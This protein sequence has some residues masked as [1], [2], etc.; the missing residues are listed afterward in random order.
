MLLSQ[1]CLSW[2]VYTINVYQGGL[3]MKRVVLLIPHIPNPRMLKRV[4]TLENDF[5]ISLIYWD[6]LLENSES[7]EISSQHRLF[8]IAIKAPQGKP[9]SR[10]FPLVMFLVKSLSVLKAEKPNIIH[11]AE[12]DMLFIAN[13][14]RLLYDSSVRIIYE[15]GDLYKFTFNVN[16]KGIKKIG[17]RI[18]NKIEEK[19]CKNISKIILTSPYFWNVYY[20][21]FVEQE[22]YLFIPNTP[23]KELFLNYKKEENRIFTIGFI[24]LIR[25]VEQLKLLINAVE[26]L[27]DDIRILIAGNGPGYKQII[28]YSRNKDFVQ[29]YGPYNYE[30]EIIQL[31]SKIDFVYSVYDTKLNNV[32]VAMPNKLYEAIAC[33]L[34]IIVADNTA[35][36]EFV[37]ENNIGL[38]TKNDDLQQL[39]ECILKLKNDTNL[40]NQIKRN[41]VNIKEK[42][43]DESNRVK[44]LK[45]YKNLLK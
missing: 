37:K 18:F 2:F 9:L 31:Y 5:N 29:I 30:K 8:K 33:E 4:K 35:L 11:V 39:K 14:Y 41:C 20:S 6:R 23:S 15:I 7:F 45:H 13:I 44:L 27:N 16:L 3:N 38:A 24:G 25:Y 28:E 21:K 26:D 34:P 10:V 19:L 40:T 17:G 36:G 43:Y 22:K 1:C 32:R 12:L 42:Y